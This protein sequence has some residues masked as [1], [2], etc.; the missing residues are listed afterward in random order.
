MCVVAV[1]DVV[2]VVVVA[3]AVATKKSRK[4]FFKPLEVSEIGALLYKSHSNYSSVKKMLFIIR[5][6]FD[7]IFLTT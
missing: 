6:K 3:A 2:V 5:S 1:A 4:V 7:A